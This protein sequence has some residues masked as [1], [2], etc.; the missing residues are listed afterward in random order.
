MIGA[1]AGDII[2]SIYEGKVIGTIDFPLFSEKSKFTDDTVMSIAVADAILTGKD[3]VTVYKE[4]GRQYARAG[5]GG[6]F[7]KWIF[8]D[9]TEPYNSYGNG[10]AMRVSPIGFALETIEKVLEEARRSAEVTH[11]HPEGIKGAQ[12]TAAAVFLSLKGSSK[13]EI[14]DYIV[15]NF[16]YN[17]DKT[18]EEI[19]K[20][21]RFE[22]SCQV[23][24]PES[25]TVFL[26]SKNFED[27]I[28]KAVFLGGDSDTIASIAGSIAQA[29]YK[30]IPREIVK[31]TYQKLSPDLLKIV[32][33]FN[34]TFKIT[35]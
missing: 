27:A 18:L 14:K 22:I 7:K 3:Y 31:K 20:S 19:S 28:R 11:N 9:D 35:L 1:I 21:Y 30:K 32:E 2:G 13:K 12:A 6:R 16:Q 33:Q 24:V 5:Y 23:T 26:E 4:Y 8:S 29:F 17:L 34:T 10:S 15:S 25:I